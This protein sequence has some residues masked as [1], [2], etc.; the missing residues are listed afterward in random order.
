MI[1]KII[2]LL[3]GLGGLVILTAACQPD[4]QE[5]KIKV[6]IATPSR[7]IRGNEQILLSNCDGNIEIIQTLGAVT[8]VQKEIKINSIAIGPDDLEYEI[9]L[10]LKLQLEIEVD[11]A[12][13]ITYSNASS[14]L[15]DV[16]ISI[17]QGNQTS[18]TIQWAKHI[19]SEKVTF[20]QGAEIYKVPY[21][22]ELD[23]PE[24]IYQ[25]KVVCP[26]NAENFTP[27]PQL[28]LPPI[29][30]STL[31]PTSYTLTLITATPLYKGPQM[32][33]GT[34]SPEKRLSGEELAVIARNPGSD[35]FLVETSDKLRG[36]IYISWAKVTFDPKEI[37]VAADISTAPTI[38][39]SPTPHISYP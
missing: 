27:V 36:W 19:Y 38:H 20:S 8:A 10:P 6:D 5:T 26:E 37:P 9:P 33:Y 32:I 1:K 31:S 14:R 29:D 4:I 16:K 21:F 24:L 15:E 11:D 12:Y 3:I 2:N 23:I 18:Y 30:T 25:E 35:W 17:A 39:P 22:Y 7:G 28:N 34:V 13:K